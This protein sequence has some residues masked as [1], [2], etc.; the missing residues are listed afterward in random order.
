LARD[1]LQQGGAAVFRLLRRILP[2]RMIPSM[3]QLEHFK[4]TLAQ[5]YGPAITWR[6]T[7]SGFQIKA[8]E[9]LPVFILSNL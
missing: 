2:D 3:Y 7:Y 9:F 5:E 8:A 6:Q 1:I 4:E